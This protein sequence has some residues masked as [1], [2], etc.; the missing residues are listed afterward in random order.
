MQIRRGGRREEALGHSQK[1]R[2]IKAE[3]RRSAE[4]ISKSE[5]KPGWGGMTTAHVKILLQA[6]LS[7]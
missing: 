4:T 6:R 3:K 1:R 7:C 2:R 5:I